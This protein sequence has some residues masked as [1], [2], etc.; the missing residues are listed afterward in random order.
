MLKEKPEDKLSLSFIAQSRADKLL[1]GFLQLHDECLGHS[2]VV[3]RLGKEV[4]GTSFHEATCR[5]SSVYKSGTVDNTHDF[6]GLTQI[7]LFLEA[8]GTRRCNVS[9]LGIVTLSLLTHPT[10]DT[11]FGFPG[12]SDSKESS[13]NAGELGSI[14]GLGRRKW[15][16]K[17]QP[18]P[19]FLP[20]ES[21]GQRSLAGYSPWDCKESDTT[22]RPHF[23]F[24]V[25]LLLILLT[26]L[27][28]HPFRSELYSVGYELLV[29]HKVNLASY[30][31]FIME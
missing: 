4:P 9:V 1:L 20:G 27:A 3:P 10:S 25:S 2:P 14:P 18:T 26:V 8:V 13:C 19:V 22:E 11:S 29:T 6:E 30:N 28:S 7:H 23:H 12:S 24:P 17:W 31:S 16:R 5:H 15:R 21:H